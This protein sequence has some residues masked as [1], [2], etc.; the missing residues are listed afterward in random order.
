MFLA[1]DR[2]TKFTHVAFLDAATKQ[3][4]AEFLR[5][6][7]AIFPYRIHTVLTDNGA[8]FTEQAR[9]RMGLPIVFAD[10]FSIAFSINL[11][12]SIDSLSPIT[13]GRTGKLRVLTA[14]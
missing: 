10:T 1:I 3:S 8:A 6:V 9:Y 12:S 4:G 5:E 7:A 11:L 14:Q 13:H 2:A